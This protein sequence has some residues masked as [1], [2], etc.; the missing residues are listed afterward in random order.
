[1]I[2][3]YKNIRKNDLETKKKKCICHSCPKFILRG[4]ECSDL[5]M[6]VVYITLL[7]LPQLALDDLKMKKNTENNKMQKI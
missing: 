6:Q 3:K 4:I 1:M 7:Q 2:W 5:V